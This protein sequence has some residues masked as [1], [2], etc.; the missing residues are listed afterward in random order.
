VTILL[1]EYSQGTNEAS[2]NAGF[3]NLFE[4]SSG[5]SGGADFLGS[6]GLKTG[7]TND[8]KSAGTT[9]RQGSLKGKISAR[10]V[11]LLPN[12][13]LKLEG[14]RKVIINGEE[15]VTILSGIVRR[16]D[17]QA[18]NTV[19]SYLI[20]DAAIS[21]RGRGVVDQAAKPGY[22]TRFINWLF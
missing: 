15:Q 14:Q 3:E 7:I 19:Y 10:V 11:E 6:F 18:D 16:S 2:T 5:T 17:I 8:S 1:M 20:S 22:I 9:T 21:Y 12:D 13:Q 4:A